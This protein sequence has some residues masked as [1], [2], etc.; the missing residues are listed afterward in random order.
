MRAISASVVEVLWSLTPS[1]I[2]F[3]TNPNGN[4]ATTIT[5]VIQWN[6]FAT[7]P[8]SLGVLAN[9]ILLSSPNMQTAGSDGRRLSLCSRFNYQ[10]GF[11]T[12]HNFRGFAGRNAWLALRPTGIYSAF[13]ASIEMFTAISLLT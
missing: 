6:A 5:A 13:I 4:I 9:G 3:A 1:A 2:S 7:L 8:N 10:I 11:R 12:G